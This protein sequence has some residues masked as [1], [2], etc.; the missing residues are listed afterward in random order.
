MIKPN[1]RTRLE[2]E[3]YY[4]KAKKFAAKDYISPEDN[5]ILMYPPPPRQRESY[6]L[7][8]YWSESTL[9]S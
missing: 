5:T 1:P 2:Q 7:T 8:T 4:H 6:L 3:G 9:S